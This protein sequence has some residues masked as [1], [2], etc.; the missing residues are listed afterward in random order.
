[1]F[2]VGNAAVLALS[3]DASSVWHYTTSE[4]WTAIGGGASSIYAGGPHTIAT[5]DS[6][7]PW[8]YFNGGWTEIGGPSVQFALNESGLVGLSPDH[9]GIWRN[10]NCESPNGWTKIGIG[11]DEIFVGRDDGIALTALAATTSV[12][13][14]SGSGMTWRAQGSPGNTFAITEDGHLYG[15]T[16]SRR[17]VIASNNT[18]INNPSWTDITPGVSIGRLVERSDSSGYLYATGAVTF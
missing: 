6:G 13:Y 1:M 7:N 5:D 8:A 12:S 17:G 15:L 4:G 10:A 16:P 9:G 18:S 2:A 11:A 3:P 14:Y